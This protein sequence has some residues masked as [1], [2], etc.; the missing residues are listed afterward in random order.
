MAYKRGARRRRRNN[1]T[2]AKPSRKFTRMVKKVITKVAEHKYVKANTVSIAF[3]PSNT[4]T[5]ST[6]VSSL[7]AL[8]SGGIVQGTGANQ[9]IGDRIRLLSVRLKA[10]LKPGAAVGA[11]RYILGQVIDYQDHSA[12]TLK[13]SDV[14]NQLSYASDYSG[15][16]SAYEFEPLKKFKILVDEIHTWDEQNSGAPRV[17]DHLFTRF[18]VK[19]RNYEGNTQ[20]YTG[21]FF[22][23]LIGANAET[24]TLHYPSMTLKYIDV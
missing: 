17:I 15:I 19:V 10:V 21:M 22:A 23:M 9:R 24:Y 18:P 12:V 4:I 7:D 13:Y 6:T 3:L 14:L 11:C 5:S 2:N 20:V 8:V 1:K 16:T